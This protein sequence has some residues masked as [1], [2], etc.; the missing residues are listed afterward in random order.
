[1]TNEPVNR[2]VRLIAEQSIDRASQ[3]LSKMLKAGAAIESSVLIWWTSPISQ[4]N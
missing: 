2:V 1:M 4:R 3:S